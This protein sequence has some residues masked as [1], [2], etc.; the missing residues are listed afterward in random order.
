MKKNDLTFNKNKMKKYL[1]LLLSTVSYYTNAQTMFA[2]SPDGNI[3]TTVTI[4][5][6]G[7]LSYTVTYKNKPVIL[8]SSMAFKFKEPAVNLVQFDH[9]KTDTVTYDQSWKPV[10]GEYN[11]IRD[12]HKELKLYLK[13]KTSGILLNVIFRVFN[14]GVGFRYEFPEQTTLTH[15][16]LADENTQ[17]HLAGDHKTFWIGKIDQCLFSIRHHRRYTPNV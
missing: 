7:E 3:K 16:V 8:S 15:F 13:E 4:S 1:L 17:F 10:W 14:E 9:L 2:G 12:H 6:S 5:S 11:N